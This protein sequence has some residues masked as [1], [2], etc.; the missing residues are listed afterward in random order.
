MIKLASWLQPNIM[1]NSM[2][3]IHFWEAS[4]AQQTRKFS[5]FYETRMVDGPL[6][7]ILGQSIPIYSH[8]ASSFSLHVFR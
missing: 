2:E 5:A 4:V 1:I 7:P 3:K 6:N 8:E